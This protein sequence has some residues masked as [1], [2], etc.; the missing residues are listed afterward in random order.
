[1]IFESIVNTSAKSIGPGQPS[2][3]AQ[4]DPG[5]NFLFMDIYMHVKG[6][7]SHMIYLIFETESRMDNRQLGMAFGSNRLRCRNQ[8]NAHGRYMYA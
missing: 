6:P 5:R 8:V 3:T 2:Q 7:Y 1:M 4:A